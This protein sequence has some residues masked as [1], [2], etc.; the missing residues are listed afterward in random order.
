[1][2]NSFHAVFILMIITMLI[3]SSCNKKNIEEKISLEDD[4]TVLTMFSEDDLPHD[5][6]FSSPVAMEITNATGVRLEYDILVGEVDNRTDIMIASKDYPDLI[7]VKDTAKLVDADALVD[8]APLI[9]TYGPN[10]KALYGEY[11]ERLRYDDGDAIYVLPAASVPTEMIEPNMGFELQHDVVQKLGYPELKTVKDFENAIQ[12]YIEMYPEINGQKTIGLSLL[13]DDW[14]WLISLGNGAG[15]AT[16]APDDGNWYIDPSTYEATYRFIR[17]EEKEYFRWLNHMYDIG[18]LD[19]ESFVQSFDVYEAKI[20]SGRVL[21]LIDAIW[22]YRDAELVLQSEG[23][24]ERTYGMYPIQLDDSTLAAD[25]RDVGYISGYGISISVNCEDPIKA[26]KFLDYMASEEGLILRHWG[27]EGQ[28]YYYDDEGNRVVN[29][30]D[31]ERRSTDPNYFMETGVSAYIYPFPNISENQ[32]DSTGSPYSI[33]FLNVEAET[34]SDIELEVLQAYNVAS[35]RELYP[36]KDEL[37]DS[38]WGV[39]YMIPIPESTGINDILSQ[40]N[41]VVKNAIIEAIVSD[42]LYFDQIWNEMLDELEIIGVYEM[43]EAFT[44]LVKKRVDAWS[45]NN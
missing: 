3:L 5:N 17:P 13:A 18:L 32:I 14:R 26:I 44:E 45:S 24:Y 33:S 19:P 35:W 6:N 30:I 11:F 39:G 2:K 9:D 15:F 28:N 40:C 27:I 41:K 10:I 38:D 37:P 21:G 22:E 4:I 43:N 12:A 16:G 8:L 25:F 29:E 42:P 23:M 36:T 34:Y 7:M 20:A 1:M 31:F